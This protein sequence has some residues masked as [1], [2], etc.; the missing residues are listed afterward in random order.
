MSV[1]WQ[2]TMGTEQGRPA[3]HMWPCAVADLVWPIPCKH[4]PHM[5]AVFPCNVPPT[6]PRRSE[7]RQ[8]AM[9]APLC[10]GGNQTL[11]S[12]AIRRNQRLFHTHVRGTHTKNSPNGLLM[13]RP[14]LVC[15][16]SSSWWLSLALS[17][18]PAHQCQVF[19][20]TSFTCTRSMPFP[21]FQSTA[22]FSPT[23]LQER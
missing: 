4:S 18:L 20:S 22:H 1:P 2:S 14:V 3:D 6:T 12:L 21:H 5:P 17:P 9:F 11:K 15:L 7:P 13:R 10:Q 8:V 19:T 23:K 16:V